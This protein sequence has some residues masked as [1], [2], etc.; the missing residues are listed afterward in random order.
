MKID[1]KKGGNVNE[2]ED[3]QSEELR[4][5]GEKGKLEGRDDEEGNRRSK[6]S[7]ENEEEKKRL[8]RERG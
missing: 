4:I 3:E 8:K 7:L 2:G 5:D 1:D 6:K